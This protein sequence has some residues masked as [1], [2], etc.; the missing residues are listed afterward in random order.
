MLTAR[1]RNWNRTIYSFFY[2]NSYFSSFIH[3]LLNKTNYLLSFTHSILKCIFSIFSFTFSFSCTVLC[4]FSP[5]FFIPSLIFH[6]MYINDSYDRK[7]EQETARIAAAKQRTSGDKGHSQPLTF[8]CAMR[9][10][11]TS[12]AFGRYVIFPFL[13][14][15]GVSIFKNNCLMPRSSV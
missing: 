3:F 11:W 14:L 8:S 1:L 13:N 2:D 9:R 5:L 7:I 10:C 15:E 4:I 6:P 12:T